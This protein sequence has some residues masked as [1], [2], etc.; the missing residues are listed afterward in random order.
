VAVRAHRLED[1][2]HLIRRAFRLDHQENCQH[3]APADTSAAL[4]AL[5]LVLMA[6]PSTACSHV[7]QCLLT[8]KHTL[9]QTV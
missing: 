8:W 9:T 3:I 4:R 2:W 6:R 1:A 5:F 7:R